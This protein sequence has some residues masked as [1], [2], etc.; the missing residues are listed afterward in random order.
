VHF[1]LSGSSS[2]G[3]DTRQSLLL[4][5]QAFVVVHFIEVFR[6]RAHLSE[7][8]LIEHGFL[9]VGT[10][11]IRSPQ[12][13]IAEIGP[14]QIGAA[15]FRVTEACSAYVCSLEMS[16]AQISTPQIGM[17]QVRCLIFPVAR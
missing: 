6:G 11:E 4:C 5:F 9:Q 16:I 17:A 8:C 12:V 7:L 1:S 3:S 15:E 13:G 2:V 14:L 10:R